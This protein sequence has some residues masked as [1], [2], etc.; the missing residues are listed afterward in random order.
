LTRARWSSSCRAKIARADE[1]LAQ[2]YRET[3]GWGKGDPFEITR[4]SNADAGV[5]S[6]HCPLE[7]ATRGGTVVSS[8][9]QQSVR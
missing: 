3:D 2:L 6:S 8:V 7:L 1:H 4:E 9:A 5:A